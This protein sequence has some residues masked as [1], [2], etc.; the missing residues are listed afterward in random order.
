MSLVIKQ[1]ITDPLENNNYVVAD[2]VSKEAVL[3]DCS[4]PDDDMMNWVKEQGF[5][6]KYI[7][8]THGHFDHVLG[9]NYYK[10]RYGVDAYLYEKEELLLADAVRYAK[11]L[12]IVDGAPVH[13]K[14]FDDK[15]QFEVGSYKIQIILTPGHTQG[16][17]CYLIE[18][19]LFSGDTLFQGT[20]G[21]TDLPESDAK[22]MQESLQTLFKKL[23]DE[24]PVYP[25]HGPITT[26]GAERSIYQ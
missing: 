5:S 16:G 21:R 14:T 12:N 10:K 4:Y 23:P 20:Y 24:M 15:M 6:L 3:I 11:H 22:K 17:V 19:H 7:L 8:L 2:A 18:G 9:V 26:I 25:G 13:V 1:F